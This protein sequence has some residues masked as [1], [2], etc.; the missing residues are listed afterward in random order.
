MNILLPTINQQ[1][2][3]MRNA[4]EEVRWSHASLQVKD[5]LNIWNGPFTN[6]IYDLSLNSPI[7]VFCKKNAAQPRL[8]KGPYKFFSIQSKFAI[9]E[10]SSNPT[11]FCSISVKPYY[12]PVIETDKNLNKDPKNISLETRDNSKYQEVS[13][14]YLFPNI[15]PTFVSSISL[16]SLI[17]AL[18][19]LPTLPIPVKCGRKRAW[20]Y[21]I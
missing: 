5:I 4:I 1:N 19:F 8:S 16:I 6:L 17:P 2:I 3:A 7:F 9:I 14:T 10:L 12:N 20:K 18:T 15:L 11:Q 21:P 13:P